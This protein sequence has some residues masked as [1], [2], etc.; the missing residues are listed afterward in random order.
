MNFVQ[1]IRNIETLKDIEE[2]LKENQRNHIMFLLGI[3]TGL[4]VSDILKLRVKD[5]SGENHLVIKEMKTK[6]YKRVKINPILKKCLKKYITNK[7]GNDYLIKS[8][9]G[10][11]KPISRTQAYRILK[12]VANE[13]NLD[14][15]GTHSMRKT[16]GY[17]YYKQTK[18][19]ATLQRLFNHSTPE[20]TLRYIGLDQDTLDN[21]MN[22]FRY[23]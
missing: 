21:A 7:P 23:Y 8:R 12:E 5:V 20:Y 11:N 10:K 3:Y 6:K 13:F 16:F 14:E 18:D 19:I 15:I 17:H 1:P 2:F 22:K 9:K 4:R